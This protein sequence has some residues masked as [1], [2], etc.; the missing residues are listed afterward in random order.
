MFWQALCYRALG[1]NAQAEKTMLEFIELY[2]R[3]E[4]A[5]WLNGKRRPASDSSHESDPP[6][7]K[8]VTHHGH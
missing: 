8:E 4:E 6:G 2:P 5:D 1:K 7:T 3:S